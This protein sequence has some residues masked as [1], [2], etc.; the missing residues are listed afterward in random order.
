M[1]AER[2][3]TP[4]CYVPL[5]ILYIHLLNKIQPPSFIKRLVV[6]SLM[7]SLTRAV[8]FFLYVV[9]VVVILHLL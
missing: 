5:V 8:T 1:R 2:F 3:G 6:L 7:L 9:V 4:R